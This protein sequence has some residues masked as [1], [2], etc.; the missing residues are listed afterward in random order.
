MSIAQAIPAAFLRLIISGMNDG[1][2]QIIAPGI[3][4]HK[5][6]PTPL[7]AGFCA[8]PNPSVWG[9]AGG[10]GRAAEWWCPRQAGTGTGTGRQAQTGTVKTSVG[11]PIVRAAPSSAEWRLICRADQ[12]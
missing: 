5:N 10:H 4:P 2:S 9:R 11:Q 8:V 12:A 6:K 3:I 7:L 1:V